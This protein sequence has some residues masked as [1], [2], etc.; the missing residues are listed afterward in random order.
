M[1]RVFSVICA[2][3]KSN[4]VTNQSVTLQSASTVLPPVT[5]LNPLYVLLWSS[6]HLVERL[7]R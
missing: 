6:L 1:Q 3:V 2:R 7:E 4:A 5:L